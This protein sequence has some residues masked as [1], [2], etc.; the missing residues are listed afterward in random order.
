VRDF[1]PGMPDD[2]RDVVFEKYREHRLFGDTD[3]NGIGLALPICK[4][5]AEM[6]GG[7]IGVEPAEGEGSVFYFT[8]PA[9]SPMKADGTREH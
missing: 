8:L 9:R 1:G 6:N 5:L 7:T 3:T 4:R 2:K